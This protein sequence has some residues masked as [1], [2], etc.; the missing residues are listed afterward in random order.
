MVD[1]ERDN[2]LGYL[3]E[4]FIFKLPGFL[5]TGSPSIDKHSVNPGLEKPLFTQGLE[6][7]TPFQHP[8]DLLKSKKRAV[9]SKAVIRVIPKVT[10]R[11]RQRHLK[12]QRTVPRTVLEVNIKQ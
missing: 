9:V 8:S 12:T 6:L 2:C 3:S 10:H 5:D 11:F 4:S 1:R 7:K